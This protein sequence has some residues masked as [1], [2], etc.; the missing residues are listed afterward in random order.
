MADA[1]PLVTHSHMPH[2]ETARM[3][4]LRQDRQNLVDQV[5]AINAELDRLVEHEQRKVFAAFK[6]ELVAQALAVHT[7][8]NGP[9]L[10]LAL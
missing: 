7:R 3:K 1:F 2:T 8:A 5:V 4:A 6:R 9:S 10:D